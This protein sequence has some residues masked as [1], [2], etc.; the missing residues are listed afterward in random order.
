[1]A[2]KTFT[3]DQEV[4]EEI[5]EILEDH[6]EIIDSG[7]ERRY[8]QLILDMSGS[9]SP[10]VGHIE[11]G[12]QA[13]VEGLRE[14]P[15]SETSIDIGIT[16]F[17]SNVS[18]VPPTS[19]TEFAMPSFRSSG[20]TAM[21]EAL[22]ASFETVEQTKRHYRDNG[23]SYRRPIV[24]LMTDGYPTDVPIQDRKFQDLIGRIRD[25]E[26]QKKW[27]F[28]PL[29]IDHSCLPAVDQL[30]SNGAKELDPG[31]ILAFMKWLSNSIN[32]ASNQASDPLA[33]SNPAMSD[34]E[35]INNL[36]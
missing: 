32:T 5:A 3:K 34:W 9:V 26:I 4:H 23:M 36:S 16:T 29:A 1:M 15:L 7:Q 35:I 25:G 19:I 31:A 8:L 33:K 10:Y 17:G 12:V 28:L 13:L 14:D 30:S 18:M 20:A 6:A 11:K 27:M 22:E 2:I 24:V 21:F